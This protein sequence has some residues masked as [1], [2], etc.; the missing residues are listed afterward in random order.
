MRRCDIQGP[1]IT[2]RGQLRCGR[3]FTTALR[4]TRDAALLPPPPQTLP[5]SW[6][7]R[8]LLHPTFLPSFALLGVALLC[9]AW[10]IWVAV[11]RQQVPLC[12][13][14]LHCSHPHALPVLLTL[15]F[16]A[17]FCCFFVRLL[18]KHLS[19]SCMPGDVCFEFLLSNDLVSFHKHTV[20][21]SMAMGWITSS[22]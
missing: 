4:E 9:F 8:T 20:T 6:P 16:F 12:C 11:P 15:L 5:C 7:R 18:G 10:S 17:F 21:K 14:I 2:E 1:G 3:I 22:C 19:F 13:G